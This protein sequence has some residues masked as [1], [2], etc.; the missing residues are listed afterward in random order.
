M[1]GQTDRMKNDE[2]TR[3]PEH[4]AR[5]VDQKA[6]RQ[7]RPMELTLGQTHIGPAR[8]DNRRC[9]R[10]NSRFDAFPG[11]RRQHGLSLTGFK[12]RRIAVRFK[13]GRIPMA[14]LESSK[15]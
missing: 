5:H 4:D 10:Q 8:P 14:R 6:R 2:S 13:I 12:R 7:R 1:S 3:A 15:K 9:A 11:G